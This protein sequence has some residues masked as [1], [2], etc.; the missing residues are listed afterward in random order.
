MAGHATR[1]Q[2]EWV[3]DAL[4][5]AAADHGVE[6]PVSY[7]RRV[8]TDGLGREA[9][10]GVTRLGAGVVIHTAPQSKDRLPI[11]VGYADARGQWH[12][13]GSRHIE[14]SPVECPAEAAEVTL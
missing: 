6:L 14:A 11:V 9:E 7:A 8:A 3:A 13:D 2:I 4:R 10:L 1:H 5:R 12:R